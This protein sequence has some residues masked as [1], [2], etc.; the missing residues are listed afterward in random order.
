MGRLWAETRSTE[1]HCIGT[2]WKTVT[3]KAINQRGRAPG[4][5]CLLGMLGT[6]MR[7]SGFEALGNCHIRKRNYAEHP[8]CPGRCKVQA[9]ADALVFRGSVCL[10]LLGVESAAQQHLQW[11]QRPQ[12][13]YDQRPPPFFD[14]VGYSVLQRR[15][16]KCRKRRAAHTSLEVQ[17]PVLFVVQQCT[18]P[19]QALQP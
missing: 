13:Q 12:R 8:Q 2:P 11:Q 10:H 5:V 14:S 15:P 3:T 4:P 7:T 19:S 16:Y 6:R 9:F 1:H 18:H 17:P